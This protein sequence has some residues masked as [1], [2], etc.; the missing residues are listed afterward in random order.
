MG[1]DI[2]TP[3]PAVEWRH[4]LELD[5]RARLVGYPPEVDWGALIRECHEGRMGGHLGADRTTWMIQRNWYWPGMLG[6]FGS[7]LPHVRGD[8]PS[9]LHG[10][11]EDHHSNNFQGT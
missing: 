7:G 8:N 6:K 5:W 10:T 3:G 1:T 11:A 2:F 4:G 9:S